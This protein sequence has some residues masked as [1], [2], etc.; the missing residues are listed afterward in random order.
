MLLINTQ[1]R[2]HLFKNDFVSM[3]L[4]RLMLPDNSDVGYLFPTTN[5]EVKSGFSYIKS[6]IW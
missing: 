5:P 3:V 1:P 4:P 6:S 2:F